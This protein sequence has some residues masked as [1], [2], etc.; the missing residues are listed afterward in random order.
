MKGKKIFSLCLVLPIISFALLYGGGYIAQF[1]ENYKIWTSA[2]GTPGSSSSPEMPTFAIL[3]CLKAS[4]SLPYGIMGIGICVLA[5]GLLIFMVMRMG[6]GD[7]DCP[8]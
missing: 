1:I 6:L 3:D 8:A 4:F 5:L 7:A 2:G